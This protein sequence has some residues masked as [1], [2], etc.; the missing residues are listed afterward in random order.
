M[1]IPVTS[2]ALG[3]QLAI[4]VAEGVPA[5]D[6]GPTCRATSGTDGMALGSADRCRQQENTARDTLWLQWGKFPA[7]DRS[8]C[9]A[10][11]GRGVPSYVVLLT[12]LE[13]ARDARLLPK[14]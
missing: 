9:A 5:F 3:L 8:Q 4:A 10:T 11:A 14:E 6:I 12:C 2:L 1:L 7:S 13:M